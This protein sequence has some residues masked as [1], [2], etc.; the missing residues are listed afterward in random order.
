[1][2]KL[3]CKLHALAAL[4]W[5]WS[6]SGYAQ[7]TFPINGVKNETT[8]SIVFTNA[9]VVVAPEKFIFNGTLIIRENK[10][11]GVGQNLSIPSGA[12]VHDLK[13]KFIYPS[14]IDIYS[15]FG[16][17]KPKKKESSKPQYD[18]IKN[19]LG[20]W[21]DAFHP[22]LNVVEAFHYDA[23]G[24]KE[25]IQ[26]G[27]GVVV[28]HQKDGVARGNGLITTLNA[29]TLNTTY[30]SDNA[31]SYYSFNKG[32][33]KQ[34]Y[35]SS[36]MG[37]I[38][39]IRQNWYDEKW[40]SSLDVK[41]FK[42]LSLE[43][44]SLQKQK[45]QV[46]AVSDYQDAQRAIQIRDEFGLNYVI[47]GSGDEY[48]RL[49]LIQQSGAGYIV[50]LKFPKAIDVEDPFD[51]MYVSTAAMKHWE[52]APSN[53]SQLAN[54]G[55]AIAFTTDGLKKKSN[56][57]PQIRKAMM[58]GLTESQAL[59]AL[60][61]APAKMIG[62]D[63]ELG[64]IEEG[65]RANFL[66]T[67]GPLFEKKTVL[68]ENWV[69]G[70]CHVLTDK[71]FPVIFGN[72]N[73]NIDGNLFELVVEQKGGK[74]IAKIKRNKSD[75]PVT[76]QQEGGL[77]TILSEKDLGPFK[78][79]FRLS[80]KINFAGK[81]WDGRAQDSEGKWFDWSAIRQKEEKTT[82]TKTT[83][84]KEIG[85][86][87][88]PNGGYGAEEIPLSENLFID[89]VIVWTSDSLGKFRGD[90]LI[91]NGKIEAVG[92]QL[93]NLDNYRRIDGKGKHLTPG[94]IDEHSH[95]AIARGVNEGTQSSSAEVRI[96]DVIDAN[97]INIYRQLAGG[98]T[99]VQLL[100][101]S[102]NPIGGQSAL[103]KLKWGYDAQAMKIQNAP[104]FI[105]FALGENVKQANWGD[106]EK[107]RFPQTRMGV[108]QVYYDAFIRA[109]EY[110]KGFESYQAE[111][112]KFKL[113]LL[114][115]PNPYVQ[116]RIDLEMEA[117]V[118]ILDSTRFISCHS[119]V[120][121]EINMLMHVGDSMG[122]VVNTFTHILE[123]Y[124]VADKMKKHGAAGSTFAD[125]WAY[126]FE[127]NDA[128]PY[129]AALL[130]EM[131]VLTGIN[132]DDPEMGRRLNQ[133][134]AKTMKYGGVSEIDALK[135]ITINP[136]KMLHIDQSTGS[137]SVGKD[138]DLVLWDSY[139]LSVY[140]QPE[141]TLID[142]TVFYSKVRDVQLQEKNRVERVRLMKKLLEAKKNGA[143]TE[144]VKAQKHRHNHCDTMDEDYQY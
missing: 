68:F 4:I 133:E 6:F 80:G 64:S 3:I 74:Q 126:K 107:I 144:K 117:L 141:M 53:P 131:G 37:A 105:K 100:H 88:Y 44:L 38:A 41:P 112:D 30:I 18:R 97:D 25:L 49:D 122:F 57:I 65:K 91:K 71:T 90:V 16:M 89:N 138:A 81:I 92:K 114:S 136:A 60:T 70:K 140:A 45:P 26:L 137:I 116:P 143:E 20:G 11:V 36:L 27:F 106:Q 59:D 2:I 17:S 56:L 40:Y 24:A 87:F 115:K 9:T 103:I 43:A 67:S 72:Y 113:P 77:V 21:N 135:M 35:P 63:A 98:V 86:L 46:F 14:F 76:I 134:A 93:D 8:S 119:Y 118:E 108:E 66:I 47:K 83:A 101:G 23:K 28:T 82:L 139:P 61:L 10:I 34:K 73:L 85:K 120:Q 42:D 54:V 33:S 99:S 31:V 29:G 124:K 78:G 69:D 127:V 52:M 111:E 132:S 109:K 96:G 142:G 12:V 32:T 13:G 128:I 15:D 94:I 1:M 123:G 62:M 110:T 95:I 7:E 129:N 58:Y 75:Y 50:P 51:A 39:L 130:N 22:E 5:L 84:T 55:V 102:A 121:S 19:G 104:G 79:P 125:W 48:K